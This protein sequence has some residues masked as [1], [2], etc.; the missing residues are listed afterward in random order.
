MAI[1]GIYGISSAEYIFDNTDISYIGFPV[2]GVCGTV[3]EPNAPMLAICIG[4]RHKE[5]GW[6][7]ICQYLDED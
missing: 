3:I 7:F 6:E 1:S 5:I 4:S 2:E